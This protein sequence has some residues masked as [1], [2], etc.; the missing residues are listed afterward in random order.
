MKKSVI[1]QLAG[2]SFVL[3]GTP[4]LP[5]LNPPSSPSPF[6]NVTEASNIAY[7]VGYTRPY[8]FR[9]KRAVS[10]STI[11]GAAAGDC[12]NDGDIDLFITYGNTSG[13]EGGGGP[14]RLYM[15]QLVE[16][17][18]GLLFEDNAEDAG[19]ANTR[20]DG[21]GNDRHSG[22]A[23]ADMDGDGTREVG[24]SWWVPDQANRKYAY[25]SML[26]AEGLTSATKHAILNANYI[27]V[28]LE[29]HYPVLYVG[30]NGRVAH[31][32]IFDLR[33]FK[34]QCGVDE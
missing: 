17:G 4:A 21:R 20:R 16:Q 19:V 7:Q 30:P 34:Q 27:K 33:P 2:L 29:A 18:N 10:D 15:N 9:G 1:Q 24:L 3:L 32:L 12:D 28:R 6:I 26:G 14:N 13:R 11:G 31:E 23:F 25:V 8:L 5:Q 22:P